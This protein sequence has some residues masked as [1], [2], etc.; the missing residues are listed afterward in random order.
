VGYLVVP[1]SLVD[2]LVSKAP[3]LSSP[4]VSVPQQ[5][6]LA[7]FWNDGHLAAYL[8]Q[9]R[10]VHAR[11]REAL[12]EALR[13]E[14]SDV[15]KP[16]GP[17]EAG[18]RVPLRVDA[19][20]AD[21]PLVDACRSQGLRVGRAISSCYL[22]T[23]GQ[24]GFCVGFASTTESTIGPAVRRLAAIARADLSEPLTRRRQRPA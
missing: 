17:P 7:R 23:P 15:L 19:A 13:S 3:R 22:G 11:R 5:M 1:V 20:L 24:T 2:T 9:L 21:G 10:E 12:M 14:A 4:L 6:Q 16:E 18:L 8:R